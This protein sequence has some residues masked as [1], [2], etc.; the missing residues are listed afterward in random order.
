M[1]SFTMHHQPVS[2]WNHQEAKNSLWWFDYKALKLG[3]MFVA[4][5]PI[6]T[7]GPLSNM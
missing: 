2:D 6:Y 7:Y 4:K 5:S 3:D 1:V